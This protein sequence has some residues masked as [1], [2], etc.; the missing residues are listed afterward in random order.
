MRP[1]RAHFVIFANPNFTCTVLAEYSFLFLFLSHWVFAK[2]HF[3]PSK[4]SLKMDPGSSGA[5]RC[6]PPPQDANDTSPRASENLLPTKK[7]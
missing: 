1:I 5:V 3:P 7:C 6:Q 2:V 4:L